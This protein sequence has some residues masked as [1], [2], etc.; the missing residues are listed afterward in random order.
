MDSAD[1]EGVNLSGNTFKQYPSSMNLPFNSGVNLSFNQLTS[2]SNDNIILP[3]T[4]ILTDNQISTL[5][6]SN[7]QYLKALYI[8]GN[9]ITQLNIGTAPELES[10][11]FSLG[12]IN[13][14]SDNNAGMNQKINLICYLSQTLRSKKMD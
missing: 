12:D 9:P 3:A 4:L 7:A 10:L 13:P 11:N 14:S 8:N 6:I 1:L 5:D 2:L